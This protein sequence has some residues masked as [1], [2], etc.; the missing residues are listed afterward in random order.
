MTELWTN[1]HSVS[2]SLGRLAKSITHR[3]ADISQ[4]TFWKLVSARTR[5]IETSCP[6]EHDAAQDS[7]SSPKRVDRQ[8][9][10]VPPLNG[11]RLSRRRSGPTHA[12]KTSEDRA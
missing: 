6:A 8:L 2:G 4:L 7:P 11:K 5:T 9:L 1:D 3:P 10:A 12:F